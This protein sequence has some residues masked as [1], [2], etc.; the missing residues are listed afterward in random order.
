MKR[1]FLKAAWC[2]GASIA[3]AT[4]GYAQESKVKVEGKDYQMTYKE[5]A[6]QYKLEEKGKLLRTTDRSDMTPA[7]RTTTHLREGETVTTVR[8]GQRPEVKQEN[9]AAPVAKKS[10]AS[11]RKYASSKTCT[12]KNKMVKRKPVAKRT[13][14]Y[15]PKAKTAT[16][17]L[18][19]TTANTTVTTPVI[20]TDTVFVSRV[21][22]VYRIMETDVFTG[23]RQNTIPLSSDFKE[24]K[25]QKE[26]G[27]VDVKVEYEDGSEMKKKYSTTEELNLHLESDMEKRED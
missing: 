22:T 11:K 18:A 14:A 10:Y 7:T 25:I 12:C 26:D 27:E 8:A 15:K 24:L 3:L 2:L 9:T 1:T 20:V 23:N 5:E 6:D 21:D 13:V 17:S 16:S 19:K 4:S